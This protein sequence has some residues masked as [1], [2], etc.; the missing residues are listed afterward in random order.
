VSCTALSSIKAH[1]HHPLLQRS[2]LARP[3][4][5]SWL[6]HLLLMPF[7][8]SSGMLYP[9]TSMHS[10]MFSPKPCLTCSWSASS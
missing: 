9:P 8:G 1:H 7:S 10:R 4:P 3:H 2:R 5:S 6:R